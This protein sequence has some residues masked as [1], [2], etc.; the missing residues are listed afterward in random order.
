MLLLEH[1][2]QQKVNLILGYVEMLIL[3]DSCIGKC[4]DHMITH[5]MTD[6]LQCSYRVVAYNNAIH[7]FT[8]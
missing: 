7:C 3:C 4:L 8:R 5:S 2:M 6:I 1:A